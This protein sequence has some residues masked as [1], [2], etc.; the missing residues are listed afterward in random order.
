MIINTDNL[1]FDGEFFIVGDGYAVMNPDR[2]EYYN[3]G[4]KEPINGFNYTLTISRDFKCSEYREKDGEGNT[5]F[6]EKTAV[7][8]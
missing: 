8:L 3:R 6:L 4:T 2:L 1:Y 7:L 5:T